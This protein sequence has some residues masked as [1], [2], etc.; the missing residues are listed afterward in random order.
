[1]SSSAAAQAARVD[2]PDQ[3]E[4]D[5]A[6]RTHDITWGRVV[7][8]HVGDARPADAPRPTF[9]EKTFMVTVATILTR[10]IPGI[11]GVEGVPG[12]FY[13]NLI[14]GIMYY[15]RLKGWAPLRTSFLESVYEEI[16]SS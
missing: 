7:D 14:V 1:M 8:R 10:D 5:A 12:D 16:K 9:D 13:S 4:I 3:D 11:V 2:P 6:Q 15:Y